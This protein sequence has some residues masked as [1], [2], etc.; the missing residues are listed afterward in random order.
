[1]GVAREESEV[2]VATDSASGRC[3]RT[4]LDVVVAFVSSTELTRG[5][6]MAVTKTE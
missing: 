6:D 3:G 5:P 4:G 2:A 1:M